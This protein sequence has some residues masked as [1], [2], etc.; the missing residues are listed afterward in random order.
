MQLLILQGALYS[1]FL[2]FITSAEG[3]GKLYQNMEDMYKLLESQVY[4][5]KCKLLQF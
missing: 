1:T 2:N 3:M 4:Y 5:V